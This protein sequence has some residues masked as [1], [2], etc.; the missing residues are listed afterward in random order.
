[1]T[2]TA[3][4]LILLIGGLLPALIAAVTRATWSSKVKVL[5]SIGI[6]ILAGLVSW[7]TQNGANSFNVS[8]F[9][10]FFVTLGGIIIMSATSYVAIWKPSG[11]TAAITNK[12]NSTPPVDLTTGA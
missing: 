8:D 7:V 11:A 12:T 6:A 9:P 2:E 10:T 5:A 1:M 3:I 4:A